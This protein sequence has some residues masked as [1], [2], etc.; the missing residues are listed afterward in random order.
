MSVRGFAPTPVAPL[1]LATLPPEILCNVAKRLPG[2]WAL[3]LV[4]ALRTDAEAHV[5]IGGGAPDGGCTTYANLCSDYVWRA[6]LERDFH[7]NHVFRY[8]TNANEFTAC[9]LQYK[10][11]KPYALQRA[12]DVY[13]AL[14]SNVWRDFHPMRRY[15]SVENNNNL[16]CMAK[17]LRMG[18]IDIA[19]LTRC[20]R[21][22][23]AEVTAAT[24]QETDALPRDDAA[25]PRA[26]CTLF[27]CALFFNPN[28]TVTVAYVRGHGLTNLNPHDIIAVRTAF[29]RHGCTR[30]WF[31]FMDAVYPMMSANSSGFLS[32]C[33]DF[34][35]MLPCVE[36]CRL[37]DEYFL[38]VVRDS[39]SMLVDLVS[40]FFNVVCNELPSAGVVAYFRRLFLTDRRVATCFLLEIGRHSSHYAR[41]IECA[42]ELAPLVDAAIENSD[43]DK[44][45]EIKIVDDGQLA[46]ALSVRTLCLKMRYAEVH[47]DNWRR[48]LFEK[49]LATGHMNGMRVC[50][51][52]HYTSTCGIV[53]YFMDTTDAP[54][55][56][57]ETAKW[58]ALA[59]SLHDGSGPNSCSDGRDCHDFADFAL[60][61]VL[62]LKL[63]PSDLF[64]ERPV[65]TTESILR[66]RVFTVFWPR[67]YP[68]IYVVM[69][70]V[71]DAGQLDMR[72]WTCSAV[73]CD[74]LLY[75]SDVDDVEIDSDVTNINA[76]WTLIQRLLQLMPI[77]AA[78]RQ[79]A[80]LRRDTN[81]EPI[82]LLTRRWA[83][84][85]RR[86][87][88]MAHMLV[89]ALARA[90]DDYN[91]SIAASLQI[92][93]MTPFMNA[94]KLIERRVMPEAPELAHALL[95]IQ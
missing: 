22:G 13:R 78:C 51:S 15:A 26:L 54:N 61:I 64:R 30:D 20:L 7:Y 1:T 73:I 44:L 2:R 72:L 23:R 60:K 59:T 88:E 38:P 89:T 42:E 93:V 33:L 5:V 95:A 27:E 69:N 39:E 40:R 83:P 19:Y 85:T 37:I 56:S 29:L 92:S 55:S 10:R 65:C 62:S 41:S 31:A 74:L 25:S 8:G 81:L 63:S 47:V 53:E 48:R 43:A 67:H 91:A 16:E 77:L 14:A 75:C 35:D 94:R 9:R 66:K 84:T 4:Y 58:L 34:Y 68:D 79:R 82:S 28:H 17:A 32:S 76:T 45:F 71:I 80:T 21:W 50:G 52:F 11:N 6:H 87:A 86:F 57:E 70:A 49:M 36:H 90:N 12:F 3:S 46:F 18:I 24:A